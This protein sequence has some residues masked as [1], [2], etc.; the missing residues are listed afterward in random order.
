MRV[1]RLLLAVVGLVVLSTSATA[2]PIWFSYRLE[3][4]S[5]PANGGGGEFAIHHPE[6]GHDWV[7]KVAKPSVDLANLWLRPTPPADD[8]A[9]QPGIS[10]F[11][12]SS[13]RFAVRVALT[14]R[15]SGVSGEVTVTGTAGSDWIHR[16]DGLY[17]GDGTWIQFDGSQRHDLSLGGHI[18]TVQATEA[19]NPSDG[20]V[21]ASISVNVS[22]TFHNPEPG[23][24]VLGGIGLLSA[25]GLKFRRRWRRS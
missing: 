22:H 17:R 2:G 4:Q 24:L 21:W 9:W 18:F 3:H 20:E 23:T 7:E 14:D 25:A 19:V 13:T 16:W 12:S 11:V 10:N 8:P 5:T 1:F 15:A 6:P